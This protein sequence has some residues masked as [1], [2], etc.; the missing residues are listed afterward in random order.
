ME[1]FP[2]VVLD[3][4][5]PLLVIGLGWLAILGMLAWGGAVEFWRL[6]RGRERLPFFGM[7][8]RRGFTLVQAEEAAGF[9]GLADAASRCA[10]CGTLDACRRALRWGWLGFEA[11]TCPNAAFFARVRGSSL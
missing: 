7:L 1:E 10:S 3:V 11:P 9:R 4:D 6:A 5:E 8:E 2:I